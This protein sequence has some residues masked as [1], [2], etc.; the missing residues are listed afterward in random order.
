MNLCSCGK[1]ARHATLCTECTRQVVTHL[2]E[3]AT[4]GV[5]RMRVHQ[6]RIDVPAVKTLLPVAVV[7][8]PAHVRYEQDLR[9]DTRPS[10]YELLIDTLVRRDHTGS[11]SIGAV[12]GAASFEID[13]HAKAGELKDTI[14]ALIATWARAIAKHG[15]LE[16][17][18]T[19]VRGAASWLAKHPKLIAGHPD[20]AQ[21]ADQL[22][23]V[24]RSAWAVI[25]RDP[26]KVYLGQCSAPVLVDE[27]IGQC[28]ADIYAPRGR[29]VVQC[30]KC[31]AVWD[32]AP[33][34]ELLLSRV[35]EQLATPPEIARALSEVGQPVTVN[36]IHGHIHR[37]HLTRHPPHPLDERQRPRYRVGDVRALLKNATDREAS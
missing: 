6:R 12:S 29:P 24:V 36:V 7:V 17:T 37:G 33:R 8:V 9:A 20:A 1:P 32:V 28:P 35:D 15:G 11:D 14:D 25:D 22:H 19:T 2:R 34:R 3:L 30:R 5:L 26:E 13:F 18:A 27:Q 23:K 4:G 10:L 31:G 21:L 16:L